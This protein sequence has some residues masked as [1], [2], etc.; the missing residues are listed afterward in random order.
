LQ[1]P[2]FQRGPFSEI[3][4]HAR[5]L[6]QE[7]A[8][9]FMVAVQAGP[10]AQARQS[11]QSRGAI[12]LSGGKDDMSLCLKISEWLRYNGDTFDAADLE[13][14]RFVRDPLMWDA[15]NALAD[16]LQARGRV[17]RHNRGV[18]AIIKPIKRIKKF[19]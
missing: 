6:V 1:F 7:Q 9:Q 3:A 13:T 18:K 4:G 15:M 11:K 12:A 8:F 14:R 19:G 5:L 2:H 16:L 10:E 17:E